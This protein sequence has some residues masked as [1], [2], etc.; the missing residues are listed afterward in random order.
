MAS[1]ATIY[2]HLIIKILWKFEIFIKIWL[3]PYSWWTYRDESLLSPSKYSVD[4]SFIPVSARP[5]REKIKTISCV[6]ID[7]GT[8]KGNF[9][10]RAVSNWW[11]VAPGHSIKARSRERE[12]EKTKS[13]L[14]KFPHSWM[15]WSIPEKVWAGFPLTDWKENIKK[16][17]KIREDKA[18]FRYNRPDRLHFLKNQLSCGFVS[19]G[20]G[21]VN[22]NLNYWLENVS[23]FLGFWS[24]FCRHPLLIDLVMWQIA[25]LSLRQNESKND[26]FCAVCGV[27]MEL[28]CW[29]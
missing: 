18:W 12:R 24:S 19:I 11:S 1:A 10:G 3:E 17:H 27:K 22:E 29:W 4:T 16:W 25:A 28:C 2:Q 13:T 15:L 9:P 20:E 8:V 5:L 7:T 23:L 26:G 14:T 6:E 21:V